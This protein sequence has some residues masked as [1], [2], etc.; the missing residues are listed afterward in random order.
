MRKTKVV[1]T[2]GPASDSQERLQ[3]LADAGMDVARQNFSHGTHTDHKKIKQRVDD[4]DGSVA[5]M[6]D[7]QGPEIRLGQVRDDTE[8]D[9]DDEVQ[10]VPGGDF[11][12]NQDRLPVPYEDLLDYL[13]PGDT[14]LI[15]DGNVELEVDSIDDVAHCTVI[16]GGLVSTKKS[17]NVPG[18]DLGL[19][20]PTD[21]DLKDIRFGAE[22]DFD[23]LSVSFVK[24]AEDLERIQ[25]ILDEKDSQMDIIAKIEHKKA[26]DNFDEILDI[27]DGIMVARGDLGVETPASEVPMLQKKIIKQCNQAGKPVITA[28]QM[29]KTMTKSP[30]ASRAEVSDV[31]NAVIDGTDAVMLSEETAVGDYPVKSLAFMAEVVSKVEE[32]LSDQVHHTVKERSRDIEDIICKNIWQASRET[33]A[34]YIIAHTSSGYTAGH[35]AKFR[36]GTDIIALT[37]SKKVERQLNLVWGVKALYTEF[38]DSV[39]EMIAGSASFLKERDLVDDS[40]ILILSAGVPTSVSGTTNMMEIRTVKSL[41]QEKEDIDRRKDT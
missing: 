6:V 16:Y 9:E 20:A 33:D 39:D 28:T 21:K 19:R 8:L 11:E 2:I 31:A 35:I 10:L 29:L 5:T 41:L 34:R 3:Q 17:V 7:T 36:P 38:P 13:Q 25:E 37:D 40:D 22:H 12:G 15:D 23:F 4:L 18:K 30:Q 1:A 26:V 27:A 24:Y 14:V 32:S